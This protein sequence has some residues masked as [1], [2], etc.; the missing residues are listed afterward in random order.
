MLQV[1]FHGLSRAL[2]WGLLPSPGRGMAHKIGTIQAASPSVHVVLFRPGR[3]CEEISIARRSHAKPGAP[4]R[5]RRHAA[6]PMAAVR[7]DS[8]GPGRPAERGP[9]RAQR[10]GALR[11]RPRPLPCRAL[12]DAAPALARWRTDPARTR[13]LDRLFRRADCRRECRALPHLLRRGRRPLRA[14]V[15][16]RDGDLCLVRPDDHRRRRSCTARCPGA[17]GAPLAAAGPC[18]AGRAC[19][20]SRWCS[21]R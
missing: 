20:P 13:P 7:A 2:S 9:G 10:A 3:V 8:L 16:R 4:V 15:R 14:Q 6:W 5:L 17:A 11:R 1:I 12:Q 18:R 19:W 21:G